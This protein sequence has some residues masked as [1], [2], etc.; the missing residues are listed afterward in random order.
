MPSLTIQLPTHVSATDPQHPAG[1]PASPPLHRSAAAPSPRRDISRAT[2][3]LDAPAAASPAAVYRRRQTP[4]QQRVRALQTQRRYIFD[5]PGM[6]ARAVHVTLNILSVGIVGLV[7]WLTG[8]NYAFG[9]S[10]GAPRPRDVCKTIFADMD[11]VD[12]GLDSWNRSARLVEELVNQGFLGYRLVRDPGIEGPYKW[13]R[14]FV[15]EVPTFDQVAKLAPVGV[16]VDARRVVGILSEIKRMELE[17]LLDV[18]K[19]SHSYQRWTGVADEAAYENDE[20]KIKALTKRV[21]A[22]AAASADLRL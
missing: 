4:F 2:D 3:V 11:A 21:A 7:G 10:R 12:G 15:R 9:A 13:K 5:Q 18:H 8:F 20:R 6:G 1:V 14:S 17:L 19:L 16:K 22:L